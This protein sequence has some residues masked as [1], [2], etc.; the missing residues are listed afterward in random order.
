MNVNKG[1]VLQIDIWNNEHIYPGILYRL[2]NNNTHGCPIAQAVSC[3]LQTEVA[4]DRVQVRSYRIRGGQSGTG[5]FL[6]ILWFPLQIIPPTAP[7]SSSSVIRV[8]YNKP[9]SEQHA[10][11][12]YSHT[13][14]RPPPAKKKTIPSVLHSHHRE[15]LRSYTIPSVAHWESVWYLISNKISG[16]KS[17]WSCCEM[18]SSLILICLLDDLES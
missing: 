8:W 6:R 10:K 9:N 17:E 1:K 4:W 16:I 13:T 11:W 3:W 15:N 2:I 18:F 12:N 5:G 7:H 14:P